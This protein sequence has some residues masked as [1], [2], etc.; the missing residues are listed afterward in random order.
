[1]VG[2]KKL[3]DVIRPIPSKVKNSTNSIHS[4]NT[5]IQE[6]A[7]EDLV[8]IGPK[9][10]SALIQALRDKDEDVCVEVF[11]KIGPE[12]IK[13]YN[14]LIQV[15]LCATDPSWVNFNST[16]LH[17]VDFR[18]ADLSKANLSS[19]N[20]HKIDLRGADLSKANLSSTNFHKVGLR[21][22]DLSEANFSSTYLHKVDFRGADLSKANFSGA[23]LSEAKDN[24]VKE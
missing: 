2:V 8:K 18:G 7:L 5:E 13:I 10:I 12:T 6:H 21:G 17:K 22:A 15:G 11:R 19:T 3:L 1:L 4:E 9:A 23:K 14:F 20:L 24:D 16:T